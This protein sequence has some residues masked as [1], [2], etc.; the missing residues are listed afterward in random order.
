MKILSIEGC[1]LGVPP[2]SIGTA[3]IESLSFWGIDEGSSARER[4]ALVALALVLCGRVPA[5]LGLGSQAPLAD[6]AT[7]EAVLAGDD[8]RQVHVCWSATERSHTAPERDTGEQALGEDALTTLLKRLGVET[9]GGL[10]ERRRLARPFKVLAE[11][12]AKEVVAEVLAARTN[13]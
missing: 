6:G 2:F 11:Q 7:A 10:L 12:Q 8:G 13:R 1:G 4:S 9:I 3:E 5:D